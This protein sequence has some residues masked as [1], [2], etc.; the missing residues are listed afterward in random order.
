MLVIGS[1]TLLLIAIPNDAKTI[2]RISPN[3]VNAFLK[4]IIILKIDYYCYLECVT[5]LFSEMCEPIIW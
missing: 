5:A 3:S 2:R 4:R 1:G